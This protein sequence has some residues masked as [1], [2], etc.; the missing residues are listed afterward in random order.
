MSA[1]AA[2]LPVHRWSYEEWRQM[3]ATG[4]FEGKRVELI[5]GK[6]VDMSPQLPPHSLA[7]MMAAQAMQ[8]AFAGALFYV[9]TQMPFRACNDSEPEPDIAVI[10][11]SVRDASRT[12]HPSTALI[13]I[14]VS[15]D[16]LKKDRGIKAD[17]YAAAGVADYWII[18]LPQRQV[19]VRRKPVRDSKRRFGYRYSQVAIYKPGESVAPLAAKSRPVA[20]ADL[21]P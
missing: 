6:I 15:D 10:R 12:E 18:N 20:V 17:L 7:I 5:D 14:E 2:Q 19:E 9:R 8:S 4:V 13:V 11:G 16:S 21:L 3:V 1:V